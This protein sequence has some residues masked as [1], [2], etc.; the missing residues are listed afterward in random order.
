[1]ARLTRPAA[2]IMLWS[3]IVSG[4]AASAAAQ[5]PAEYFKGKTVYLVVGFGPGGGNDVWARTIARHIGRHWPGNPNVIVQ[6]QPGAGGLTLMNQLGAVAPMDGTVIG[7]VN[8]GIPLEPLLGGQGIQ[9]DPRKLS[10]IGSPDRDITICAARKDA[11]VQRMQDLIHKELVVG[12]TGSGADTAIY[13]EFLAALL[14]MKF[15]TVKGYKGSNDVILAMER[16]EVEGIC[17]AN[18]SLA[19]QPIAREGRLNILFQAAMN[20]DP[21]LKDVPVGLGLARNDDEKLALQLFFARVALGRP[22]VGPPGIPEDRLA[23]I[24]KAFADTLADTEF[25]G[26]ATKQGLMVDA[27]TG[28]ELLRLIEDA[29]RTPAPIVQRTIKALGRLQQGSPP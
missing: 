19:R 3:V 8:R 27:I 4:A 16:G 29:Y 23:A 10:W 12:A 1:M 13:P 26:E 21:R 24:R 15:K 9:F 28:E 2:A 25:V 18:D 14:G 7:L 17:V 20:P 5:T 11:S 22:F 6:N